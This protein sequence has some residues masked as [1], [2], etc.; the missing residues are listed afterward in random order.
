MIGALCSVQVA[1][2][3]SS[4]VPSSSPL[5]A[6]K[7]LGSTSSSLQFLLDSPGLRHRLAVRARGIYNVHFPAA[8]RPRGPMRMSQDTGRV[9]V[10]HFNDRCSRRLVLASSFL[11]VTIAS[12]CPGQAAQVVTGRSPMDKL[13]SPRDLV[14]SGMR[15]FQENK[16][17]SSIEVFDQAIEIDASYADYLWQRGL[18]LYYAERFEDA[19]SQFLRDV[20]LNPRDTEEAIWNT[21]SKARCL[22]YP[23]MHAL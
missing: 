22:K 18:S 3:V 2:F 13:P 8:N 9:A 20:R 7:G 15:R 19:A 1:S 4:C 14:N 5:F 21:I 11:A 23:R 10:T 16:V 17:E 12:S 6:A